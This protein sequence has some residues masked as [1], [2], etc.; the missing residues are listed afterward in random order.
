MAAGHASAPKRQKQKVTRLQMFTFFMCVLCL[1][2]KKRK[3]SSAKLGNNGEKGLAK[4][5]NRLAI[6]ILQ[7]D[8]CD[9]MEDLLHLPVLWCF[10]CYSL[11]GTEEGGLG[12]EA[13][14]HAYL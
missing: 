9:F 5:Q 13:R 10:P 3:L 12:G 14:G 6:V 7:V 2:V 8:F 4:T 11:E 1:K